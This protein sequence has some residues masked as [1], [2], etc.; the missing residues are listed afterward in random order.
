MKKTYIGGGLYVWYD[1]FHVV[2]ATSDTENPPISICLD[3]QAL[4]ALM[5]YVK[6]AKEQDEANK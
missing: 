2:L 6:W 4:E 3:D 1:G 5:A